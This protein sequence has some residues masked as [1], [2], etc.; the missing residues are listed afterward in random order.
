MRLEHIGIAV[1]SLKDSIPLFEKLLQC[2]CDKVEEAELERVRTAFF[3]LGPVKLELLESSHPEGPV[4]RFLSKRGPGMHH[5]ALEV[6]DLGKEARR[7]REEGFEMI[8]D[9]PEE[10][11]DSKRIWFLHPSATNGVL[12]ELCQRH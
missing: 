10:G 8:G 9:H 4:A 6:E 7:L 1:H 12:I 2:P 3:N 11:A 5:M